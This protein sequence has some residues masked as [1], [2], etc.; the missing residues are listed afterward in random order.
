MEY[1]FAFNF[2]CLDFSSEMLCCIILN[3]IGARALILA[4]YD[5]KKCYYC[6]CKLWLAVGNDWAF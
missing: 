5:F 3:K 2:S 1:L 4:H 6:V